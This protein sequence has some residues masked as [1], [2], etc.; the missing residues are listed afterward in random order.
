MPSPKRLAVY[1][2]F[3][4]VGSATSFLVRELLRSIA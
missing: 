3:V 1:A 2:V 4:V